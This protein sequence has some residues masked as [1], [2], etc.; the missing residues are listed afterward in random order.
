MNQITNQTGIL[1]TDQVVEAKNVEHVDLHVSEQ[2]GVLWDEMETVRDFFQNFYDANDVDEIK[3]MINKK[4]VEIS[5]PAQFDYNELLYMHTTK[6]YN[7]D[8]I[9]QYGEGFKAS[10]V[11]AMRNWDCTVEMYVDNRKLRFYFKGK[12]FGESES[13]IIMCEVSQINPIQGTRLVVKNCSSRL[14]TEFEFGLKHFYYEQNPLFGD[15]IINDR[16]DDIQIYKSTEKNC[17]YLFYG[18]LIR[19]KMNLPIVVVCNKSYK[20]IDDKTKFDRDRKAFTQDVKEMLLKYIFQTMKYIKIDDL[21]LHVKDF[22][23]KGDNEL[24]IIAETRR[25]SYGIHGDIL[26]NDLFPENYYAKESYLQVSDN[27]NQLINPLIK[28]VVDEYRK[29]NYN[30]CPR[31][32][33]RFGMKTPDY[34]ARERKTVKQQNITN[35]YSRDLTFWEKQGVNLLADF[36]KNLSSEIYKRFKDAVYSIG[37][38]DEIIGELK[39]KRDY[40]KQHVFLNK[41]VF[42]LPF[43]DA[44]AILI[45]E[46]SHMYGGDGGRSFSDALTGF[47]SLIL[48]NEKALEELKT[49]VSR[50]KEILTNVQNERK[51]S[52][53]NLNLDELFDNLPTEKIKE[54]LMSIPPEECFKLLEKNGVL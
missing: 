48:K 16:Y 45:H 43:N 15:C 28:N 25:R 40:T 38:N 33:S 21:L 9:G 37:E 36:I 8:S 12:K 35:L 7:S 1:D 18:K 44:L 46:W 5:A 20:R 10:L 49:Y 2:W 47:I 23:I 13:R 3:V 29:A 52:I 19:S 54:I 34:I 51:D 39:T 41:I 24:A 50:W 53:S 14:L 27:D 11:N 6:G 42:T 30:C 26:L 17:G 32:M 22:W 31:Y 4:T